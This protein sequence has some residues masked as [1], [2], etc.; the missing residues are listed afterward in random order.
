MPAGGADGNTGGNRRR[1][2]AAAGSWNDGSAVF[3]QP[4]LECLQAGADRAFRAFTSASFQ[5]GAADRADSGHAGPA[6]GGHR[7]R[8]SVPQAESR[9][10]L[11]ISERGA[12]I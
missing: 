5:A 7:Q 3:Y 10:A 12:G 1:T 4:V 9:R 6:D 11:W 8:G 2:G